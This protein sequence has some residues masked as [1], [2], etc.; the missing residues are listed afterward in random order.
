[1]SSGGRYKAGGVSP[2]GEGKFAVTLLDGTVVICANLQEA[3]E[4]LSKLYAPKNMYRIQ[5]NKTAET[6]PSSAPIQSASAPQADSLGEDSKFSEE[7]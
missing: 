6:E 2:R 1:M 4:T 5:S 7:A 3:Q